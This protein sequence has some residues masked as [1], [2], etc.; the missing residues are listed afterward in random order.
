MALHSWQ[1]EPGFRALHQLGSFNSH[2]PA[3]S[4]ICIRWDRSGHLGPVHL[5]Y[6]R[7]D[8]CERQSEVRDEGQMSPLLKSP[9]GRR[10]IWPWD[11]KGVFGLC[12][13]PPVTKIVPL[14]LPFPPC[15]EH[16]WLV[17][18]LY[19]SGMLGEGLRE[20]WCAMDC[21]SRLPGKAMI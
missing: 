5:W 11:R 21:G 18:S 10:A 16:T 7:G 1:S 13:V 4:L 19:C 12:S 20:H 3:L 15:Q 8:S 2:L 6:S 17:V 9:P 14:R